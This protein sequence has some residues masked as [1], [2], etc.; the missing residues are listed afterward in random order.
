VQAALN[1]LAGG[2]ERAVI[3]GLEDAPAALAGRAGTSI[4]A[5]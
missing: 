4:V 1:F 2:G 5:S 3:A